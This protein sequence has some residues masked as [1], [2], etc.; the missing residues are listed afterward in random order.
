MKTTKPLVNIGWVALLGLMLV[1]CGG[2]SNSPEPASS[3]SSANSS[4]SSDSQS[5]DSQSSESISSDSSSSASNSSASVSTSSSS[6]SA[7]SSEGEPQPEDPDPESP[8]VL[9]ELVLESEAADSRLILSWNDSAYPQDVIFNL[10]LASE[11]VPEDL[12]QCAGLEGSDYRADVTSPYTLD[13]LT[14]GERYYLRVEAAAEGFTPALSPLVSATPEASLNNPGDYAVQVTGLDP[15]PSDIVALD[16]QA[17]IYYE[18]PESRSAFTVSDGTNPP[19]EI[20]VERVVDGDT[21]PY[22][23]LFLGDSQNGESRLVG[24]KRYFK[25]QDGVA[26][27]DLWVTDGTQAGTRLL[28]T[29]QDIGVYR[30][31]DITQAGDQLFF[32]SMDALY[33]L[34]EDAPA[35]A[36]RIVEGIDVSRGSPGPYLVGYSRDDNDFLWLSGMDGT[37]RGLFRIN[38][39]DG[40][41]VAWHIAGETSSVQQPYNLIVNGDHLYFIADDLTGS[42]RTVWRT[43]ISA[44]EP[45]APVRLFDS[46]NTAE[47]FANPV[48]LHS[49]G[50]SI[51]F[52]AY[53][54]NSDRRSHLD[55]KVLVANE[56]T[57]AAGPLPQLIS[58]E[59]FSCTS[60][61]IHPS[62]TL[63][64]Q[65]L[66]LSPYDDPSEARQWWLVN[67]ATPH[68]VALDGVALDAPTL[69]V[70]PEPSSR[71]AASVGSGAWVTNEDKNRLIYIDGESQETFFVTEEGVGEPNLVHTLTNVAGNLWFTACPPEQT[72]YGCRGVWW[73]PPDESDDEP[74][75]S[76]G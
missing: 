32:S 21:V 46:S 49:V 36:E 1:G 58:T 42:N 76:D 24:S 19:L 7:G 33:K 2:S 39:N 50:D 59:N 74:A 11:P 64:Q 31:F 23:K 56:Q 30:F 71:T 43:T 18:T 51:Y 14:N 38:P 16:D 28:V 60:D 10:C 44:D 37:H 52:A 69:T 63:D 41:V 34:D 65:L 54:W 22:Q 20:V 8:D 47:S 57:D 12:D 55:C 25:A 73:V 72:Y 62:V 75:G 45:Q 5:S 6:S 40:D 27:N 67:N 35:G 9:P 3:R 15:M 70:T 26:V 13:G 53:R 29:G 48:Q 4:Q 66:L 17:I 61:F 68:T